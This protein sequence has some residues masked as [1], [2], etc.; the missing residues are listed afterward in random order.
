MAGR[1]STSTVPPVAPPFANWRVIEKCSPAT[2]GL[3]ESHEHDVRPLRP[4]HHRL[5]GRNIQSVQR[6]HP[7]KPARVL[8]GVQVPHRGARG[9]GADQPIRRLARGQSEVDRC[10]PS[11]PGG[12]ARV[13]V[14]VAPTGGRASLAARPRG[15]PHP[16]GPATR[17]LQ[18]CLE[19][20]SRRAVLHRVAD[21][22][23][24]CRRSPCRGS[25]TGATPLRSCA[26]APASRMA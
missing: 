19:A 3:V 8:D 13:H 14:P 6:T 10:R 12:V 11:A 15:G 16:P 5:A 7:R 22:R 25:W 24:H 20:S 18:A 9:V 2:K 26:P 17:R 23:D 4:E 21:G 1:T